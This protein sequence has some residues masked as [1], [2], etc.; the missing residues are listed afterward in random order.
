MGGWVGHEASKE[1]PG[2]GDLLDSLSSTTLPLSVFFFC[3]GDAK[4]GLSKSKDEIE[5]HLL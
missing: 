2:S 5:S 4:V 3:L 1:G